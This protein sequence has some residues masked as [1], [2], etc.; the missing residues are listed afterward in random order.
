MNPAPDK[1]QFEAQFERNLNVTGP[2]TLDVSLR[3]GRLRVRRGEDGVVAIRGVFRARPSILSWS[4]PE[5]LVQRLASNPPVEQDG[6][7]IGIGD[8][9]GQWVLRRAYFLLEVT[10]PADTRI[11]AVVDSAD[12][13]IEGINGPVDCETESGEIQIA[14]IQSEVSAATDAG[15]IHT[16]DVA[17]SIDVRTDSGGIEALQIG[18]GIDATT[19]SGTIRLSQTSAAP[20]YARS[21]SGGVSL[22]VAEGAGYTVRLRT[23]SGRIETPEMMRTGSSRDEIEGVIRGGGSLVKIETDSGD[24]EI[25]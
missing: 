24:I 2:V 14:S 10:A 3:A 7:R 8:V 22:K 12:L 25:A 16:R 18:K 20:V 6:N 1:R 23:D 17:G 4:N 19:D 21:D 13:R 9:F 11:R 15:S 5:E